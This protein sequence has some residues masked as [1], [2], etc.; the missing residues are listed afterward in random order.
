MEYAIFQWYW[1]TNMLECILD[2]LCFLCFSIQDPQYSFYVWNLSPPQCSRLKGVSSGVSFYEVRIQ[3]GRKK[4]PLYVVEFLFSIGETFLSHTHTH[5]HTHIFM[6]FLG[7]GNKNLIA[8]YISYGK[9]DV[10]QRYNLVAGRIGQS[11][12]SGRK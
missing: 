10:N 9:E 3:S 12:T 11:D 6:A 7:T 1:S 4:N 5:T 2:S 8:L